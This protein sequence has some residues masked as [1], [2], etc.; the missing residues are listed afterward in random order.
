METKNILLEPMPRLGTLSVIVE[1]F[2]ANNADIYIG[3]DRKGAAPFVEPLLIGDY[4]IRAQSPGFVPASGSFEIREKEKT[5]YKFHMVSVTTARQE[6]IARWSGWK[7]VSAGI[8]AAAFG[9]ST[10][11]YFAEK[12]NNNDYQSATETGP[13]MASRSQAEKNQ[14]CFRISLSIGTAAALTSV[15]SWFMETH[16]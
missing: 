5:L 4:K 1:P 11:F 8:S 7:W 13:A 3:G 16:Q 2:E 15:F 10:Y 14:K 12:K 9:A 6:A